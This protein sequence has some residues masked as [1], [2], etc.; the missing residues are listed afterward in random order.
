MTFEQFCDPAFRREEQNKIKSEA[1][2]ASFIDLDGLI[3]LSKFSSKFFGRSQAWFAQKL[4][5]N[6]VDGKPRKFSP[7]ECH[8]I[9]EAFRDLSAQL[10]AFAE[11]I[12]SAE[13]VD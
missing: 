13:S 3:N 11:N 1:V 6:I 9:A 12:D 4:H 8:R 10:L 2:W 5:G 7:E